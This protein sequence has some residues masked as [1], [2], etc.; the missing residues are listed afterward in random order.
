MKSCAGAPHLFP[1]DTRPGAQ[2]GWAVRGQWGSGGPEQRVPLENSSHTTACSWEQLRGQD[3][4]RWVMR[5]HPTQRC[6]SSITCANTPLGRP[7]SGL[8]WLRTS[9]A[10][11][12]FPPATPALVVLSLPLVHD[13]NPLTRMDG[14]ASCRDTAGKILLLK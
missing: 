6:V 9:E 3:P 13:S 10:S 11:P 1:E 8:T 12:L 5:L 14:W 2:R 7:P 4:T